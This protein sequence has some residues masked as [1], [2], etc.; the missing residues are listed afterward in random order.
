M[1][2]SRAKKFIVQ[3]NFLHGISSKW[4]KIQ[5]IICLRSL[6]QS[7]PLHLYS[8]RSLTPATCISSQWISL[9]SVGLYAHETVN[10]ISFNLGNH[11]II[12]EAA[13]DP[14]VAMRDAYVQ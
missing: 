1:F 10:F 7:S 12:K 2:P 14:C 4:C 3:K 8:P 13:I 9:E 11:E 5:V 6:P